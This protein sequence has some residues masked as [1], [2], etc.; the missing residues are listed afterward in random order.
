VRFLRKL[1]DLGQAV[2]CTI[3]QP[4]SLLIEQFDR[5]FAIAPGGHCYYFGPLGRNCE[6]VVNYFA[7]RGAY[8]PPTT[9][10]AE[11]LLDAGVGNVRANHHRVDWIKIWNESPEF[12]AIKN[13]INSIVESR[14]NVAR[15]TNASSGEFAASTLDQSIIL[16]KRMWLNYWRSPSYLYGNLFTTLSTAIAAGFTFW[17]LGESEIALQERL[18]AA[19][20]FIFLP[21]PFMN[22]V[23]P[24]FFES[25]M[26]WESRE[27]PSRVYGWFAFTTANILC[28]IPYAILFAVIYFVTWYF[29]VGFPGDP[30]TAGYVFFIIMIYFV[31]SFLVVI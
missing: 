20:M 18:F 12:E 5:V 30:S 24:K 1:A 2:L 6:A 23:V 14:R 16:T 25:R 19:F 13:E 7:L 26:L 10:V 17:K 4:S 8:C 29:P 22:S 27:L 9:N 15:Q 3:H 11:F 31:W 28:E 21:A